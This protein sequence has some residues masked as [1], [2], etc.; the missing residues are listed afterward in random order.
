MKVL[1][2]GL[3]LLV[4]PLVW[5][6][7]SATILKGAH[8]VVT[9]FA[10][11]EAAQ[12]TLTLMEALASRYNSYFLFDLSQLSTP[13][14][15]TLY[16]N[17]ADFD[18]GLKGQVAEA[19]SD[20]VYLHYQMPDQYI[21]P[22]ICLLKCIP[23]SPLI[24]DIL[25]TTSW[26]FKGQAETELARVG[27]MLFGINSYLAELARAQICAMEQFLD[28]DSAFNRETDVS[29]AQDRSIGTVMEFW[30]W[31]YLFSMGSNLNV[32][33]RRVLTG[34]T[35]VEQRDGTRIAPSFREF[36]ALTRNQP[37]K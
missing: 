14:N 16:A 4:S 33:T 25:N 2:L 31:R 8:Y 24:E 26:S 6:A 3:L 15:V 11:P 9:S 1:V 17:K 22:L 34:E 29:R 7:P 28:A 21:Y 27:Y 30:G 32:I 10:C 23:K 20:Y 37:E 36:L 5:S 12:S 13:W 19:P 18:A 35:R